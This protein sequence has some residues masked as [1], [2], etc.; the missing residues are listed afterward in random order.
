M[1][2]LTWEDKEAVR[3]HV[4]S[5][6]RIMLTCLSMCTQLRVYVHP[7]QRCGT[8]KFS[9]REQFVANL[10]FL[11]VYWDGKRVLLC[12]MHRNSTRCKCLPPPFLTP[13]L[14][15]SLPPPFLTPS[16]PPSLPPPFLTPSLSPSPPLLPSSSSPLSDLG[17]SRSGSLQTGVSYVFPRSFWLR[18]HV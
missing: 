7:W 14:P 15:P 18:N 3:L 12:L 10:H 11:A 5:A 1:K 13:S 16:L 9:H 8:C 4:S 2:T 17:S 6:V